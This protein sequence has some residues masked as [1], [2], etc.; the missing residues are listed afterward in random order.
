MKNI[1]LVIL[2]SLLL[3]SCYTYKL[4]AINNM[5]VGKNYVVKLKRGGEEME[6]RCVRVL[7][8][9]V[10]LRTNKVNVKFP[11][12]KIKY[13]KR[14]KMSVLTII[15]GVAVATTGI[16][17]LLNNYEEHIPQQVPSN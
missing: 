11:M 3:Q 10:L 12:S 7:T 17:V 14:K 16:V 2:V 8:D 1:L 6:T 9:T 5:Q 15:G 13:I 4:T